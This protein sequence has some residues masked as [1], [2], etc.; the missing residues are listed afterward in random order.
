VS[1]WVTIW[2]VAAEPF[3]WGNAGEGLGALAVIAIGAAVGGA[4]RGRTRRGAALALAA[5]FAIAGA[6]LWSSLEHLRHHR[7]CAEASRQEEGRILEGVVRDHR[8]LTSYW[9][10]PAAEFFTLGG[11]RVRFPLLREGCGYHRTTLEGGPVREGLRLR[12]LEW[13][14]EILRI[15]ADRDALL[16]ATQARAELRRER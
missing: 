7:A 10:R 13:N 6:M 1:G 8:P 12:L 4:V 11:Q 15:D 3:R 14:G 5:S 16:G 9:Q 2:D